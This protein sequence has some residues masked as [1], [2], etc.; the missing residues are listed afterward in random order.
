MNP[1]LRY[2]RT[3][4]CGRAGG[5][6]A[7]IASTAVIVAFVAFVGA[8]GAVGVAAVG[9]D[10]RAI[11]KDPQA[12]MPGAEQ[13]SRELETC[14]ATVHCA[15]Q[16]RC[17]EGVCR[18]TTR[19]TVGD[20][21]AAL[22]GVLRA[23]GKG[24]DAIKAYADGVDRY[25][26]DKVPLPPE[27]DCAYGG[28]LASS[29]GKKEQSELAARVLHR[30]L[31]AVPAGSALY[32][33]AL[34]DLAKLAELGLDPTV[35]AKPQAADLYLSKAPLHKS[36]EAVTISVAA[37]PMPSGKS[38]GV[39]IDRIGQPDL[40]A[41]L[42]ACWEAQLAATQ[43]EE[44]VVTFGLKAKYVSDYEDEPG[45]YAITFEPVAAAGSPAAVAEECVRNAL[46]PIKK[47]AG[48]R[49]AVTTKLTITMR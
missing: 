14:A 5:L 30:C 47:T 31:L 13:K 39:V 22:G 43:R 49:D 24:A 36:A 40:R 12:A 37:N 20:Y 38:F 25:E 6:V 45:F 27:L 3:A 29:N 17:F 7:W 21:F 15:D 10:A 42:L 46:E 18:R 26:A 28:A 1:L 11:A 44:L 16:L 48:L 19:S 9:C 23:R 34:A 33:Q 2:S 41:P 4:G 32:H 8:V 35:L